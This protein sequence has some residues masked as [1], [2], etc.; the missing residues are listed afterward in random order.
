MDD[1]IRLLRKNTIENIL[2]KQD[3]SFRW[4]FDQKQARE[5]PQYVDYAPKSRATLWTLILL[6]ELEAPR[7]IPQIDAAL[8]LVTDRFY[9][10]EYGVFRLP[11][12]SHFPIPCLNGNM[13]YLHHYFGSPQHEE[14][15]KTISFFADWQRFDDG[16]FKTPGDY[17]YLSNRCCYGKHTCYWGVTK[18]LKGLSYI[19]RQQRTAQ[20]QNLIERCIGFVLRHEVCFSSHHPERLIH[21]D[22]AM[23]AFP[24]YKSDVVELLWLLKREGVSGSETRRAVELLRSKRNEDGTWVVEKEPNTIIPTGRKGF[25]NPFITEKAKAVLEYYG[26]E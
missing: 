7:G 20:V 12:M 3:A 5:R 11:G 13:I 25:A 4:G 24:T 1:D 21:P 2:G 26:G 23:L 8:K 18:L 10:P 14:V 16:G 19:P 15:E 22:I 17:P 9:A 6:A